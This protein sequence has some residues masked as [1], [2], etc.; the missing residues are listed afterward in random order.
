MSLRRWMPSRWRERDRQ[1]E[2][3]AH[4][5]LSTDELIDQGRSP[6]AARREARLRFGNPR[7]KLEEAAEMHRLAIVDSL[8]RDLRYAWRMFLR[9]PAFTFTALA[10]LAVVIGANSAVLSLA[11]RLLFRALPYP[12]ADRLAVAE[13][14]RGSARGPSSG[15]SLD[16]AMWEALRDNVPSVEAALYSAGFGRRVNLVVGQAATVVT[17]ERVSASFFHVLGVAPARGRGFTPEEDRAGGPAVA[18]LSHGLWQR[19]FSGAADILGRKILLKGEPFEVVGVMP[20]EFEA[21]GVSADVWTPLRASR[22]GEGGGTNFENVI[23]LRDGATWAAATSEMARFSRETFSSIGLPR[24]AWVWMSVTPFKDEITSG[25]REPIVML[26]AGAAAVL[27]IA[28]VNLAALTLARGRTRTAEIATRIALGGSRRAVVRQLMIESAVVGFAGGAAGLGVSWLALNGLQAL[29]G[30]TYESWMRATID[31]RVVVI[32]AAVSILTSAIVGLVPALQTSRIDMRAALAGAGTRSVTGG[33]RGAG[34]FAIVTA[35]VA[36]SVVLL[37]CAGLLTRTFWRLQHLDAGFD[38]RGVMTA[39][40]SLQDARYRTA[41]ALKRLVDG[42]LSRLQQTPGVEAAAVSLGLP[43]ERL[44]NNGVR[45]DGETDTTAANVSYVSADFF[46]T[47]RIPIKDGRALSAGDGPDAPLVAVVNESFA[48]LISRNR[49]ALHR[50]VRSGGL[51]R[52]IVGIVGNVKQRGSGFRLAGMASGPVIDTPTMYVPVGQVSDAFVQ[53]VHTWFDPAWTVRARDEAAGA[54]ALRRAIVDTD[55]MLPIA[56]IRGMADVA[57]ASIAPQRLLM[58][59]V[60]VLAGAAALLAGVGIYGVVA[61]S[62]V[63]RRREVGIRMALG[64]SRAQTIWT[65]AR[66]G[67]VMGALGCGIGAIASVPATQIVASFLW[68]VEQRDAMTYGGVAIFV[69]IV[70]AV[71]TLMSSFRLLRLDPARVLR[72]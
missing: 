57:G 13:W 55:P 46:S 44:L 33:R 69:L 71:A 16:G 32:T 58:T 53:L 30:H 35:E 22:T 65:T 24:D 29:G 56:E 26:V 14:H 66:T 9:A 4:L 28:C 67:V 70:A 51:D 2:M 19:E 12:D 61:Q 39:E 50:R 27:L 34:R 38:P 31:V 8:S 6:D 1:R 36:L 5:D 7:V 10:T 60:G 17:Q 72:E 11:D 40:V 62:V 52:E 3:R 48:R 20:P 21:P 41:D 45:L 43:Y 47:L 18:V 25:D 42:S 64:A 37:V 63:E 15:T 49:P 54:D 59:L 23:R 68:G